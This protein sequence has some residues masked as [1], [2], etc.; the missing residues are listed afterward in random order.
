[1]HALTLSHTHTHTSIHR[2]HL[3]HHDCG[4]IT[5]S[6]R[7][8]EAVKAKGHASSMRKD[9][10]S[11]RT[12]NTVTDISPIWRE[13]EKRDREVWTGTLLPFHCPSTIY[14][15]LYHHLTFLWLFRQLSNK[16]FNILYIPI[17]QKN[18]PPHPTGSRGGEAHSIWAFRKEQTTIYQSH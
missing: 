16:P 15:S 2:T 7:P 11:S 14:Y 10:S 5:N 9:T 12:G 8:S 17:Q 18:M 1:M 6:E 3:L 4:S 13:A